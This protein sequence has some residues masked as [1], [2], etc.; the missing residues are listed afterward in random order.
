MCC[1]KAW[2]RRFNR[3]SLLRCRNRRFWGSHLGSRRSDLS[4]PTSRWK[5]FVRCRI[6]W[7]R[8]LILSSYNRWR[9]RRRRGRN[10]NHYWS[11]YNRGRR[12]G[13]RGRWW[14]CDLVWVRRPYNQRGR[15]RCMGRMKLWLVIVRC[16]CSCCMVHSRVDPPS[17][18]V[19]IGDCRWYGCRV[20]VVHFSTTLES[21]A[22]TTQSAWFVIPREPT[23]L[24]LLLRIR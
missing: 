16:T 11:R 12:R 23:V 8:R 5:R 17:K 3:Y 7:Q 22:P 6:P 14:F 2:E 9:R 21:T 4:S 20:W 1:L 19:R 18:L 10:L 15:W 24:K 13:R